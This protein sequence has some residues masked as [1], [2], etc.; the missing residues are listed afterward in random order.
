[1]TDRARDLI[2]PV[3]VTAS[4]HQIEPEQSRRA[5][6]TK[7]SIVLAEG[8]LRELETSAAAGTRAREPARCGRW[9]TCARGYCGS[10]P[11]ILRISSALQ[12]RNVVVRRLPSR[13]TARV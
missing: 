2:P 11:T 7:T 12:A 10:L 8:P 5:I 4:S 13:T 6:G 3:N 1:V 9:A